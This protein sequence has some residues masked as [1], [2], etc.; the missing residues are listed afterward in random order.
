MHE[1]QP[2]WPSERR[3]YRY[4]SRDVQ[5]W[6]SWHARIIG[7]KPQPV[8]GID[9]V[10]FRI[11]IPKACST[12]HVVHR[13]R[14][15]KVEQVTCNAVYHCFTKIG[16]KGQWIGRLSSKWVCLVTYRLL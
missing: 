10:V 2:S 16:E 14:Y 6:I 4:C 12:G 5:R 9:F 13:P 11:S 1:S 3:A 7:N 15:P 8:S